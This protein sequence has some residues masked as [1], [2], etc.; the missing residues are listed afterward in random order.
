MKLKNL[1]PL[2]TFE[3]DGQKYEC[4]EV[5]PGGRIAACYELDENGNYIPS[6][7]SYKI[8]LVSDIRFDRQHETEEDRVLEAIL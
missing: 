8:R 4:I 5:Y 2:Q 3:L 7:D 6:G 1:E